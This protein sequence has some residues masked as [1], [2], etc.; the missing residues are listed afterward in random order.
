MRSVAN[1]SG[2]PK[3][4]RLVR[5][6]LRKPSASLHS[7][8]EVPFYTHE[9][10]IF[11]VER[12]CAR[13]D[14]AAARPPK[15]ARQKSAPPAS[16]LADALKAPAGKHPQPSTEG[17][18]GATT[19]NRE[20]SLVIFRPRSRSDRSGLV[21]LLQ[22]CVRATDAV[23]IID[24]RRLGVLLP[25]TAAGNALHFVKKVLN[26]AQEQGVHLSHIVHTYP[27][28]WPDEESPLWHEPKRQKDDDPPD[29]RSKPQP[30]AQ[31]KHKATHRSFVGSL[32]S[33][34]QSAAIRRPAEE[35]SRASA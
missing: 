25:D 18:W 20:F 3:P 9:Q 22:R 13:A 27:A 30:P 11:L 12:E 21:E 17:V 8:D 32:V 35:D 2:G 15:A 10:F 14:R 19:D 16:P 23:G 1:D 33:W 31:P 4:K 28:S 24:A 6:G 7:K 34:L 29:A 26:L 5:A